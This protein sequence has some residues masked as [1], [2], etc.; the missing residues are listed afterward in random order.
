[1]QSVVSQR[2]WPT[3]TREV[4]SR[5]GRVG[6]L[7]TLSVPSMV[8]DHCATATGICDVRYAHFCECRTESRSD[9]GFETP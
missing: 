2:Q 1:M 5:S 8:Y 9:I 3:A 4:R 7:T 6:G